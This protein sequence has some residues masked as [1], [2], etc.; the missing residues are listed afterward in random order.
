MLLPRNPSTKRHRFCH[1]TTWFF[2]VRRWWRCA[3]LWRLA[4]PAGKHQR[5]FQRPQGTPL[6]TS[7]PKTGSTTQPKQHGR[8]EA[9]HLSCRTSTM[10]TSWRRHSLFC[11][12]Q[13]YTQIGPFTP[14]SLFVWGFSATCCSRHK[15]PL[16]LPAGTVL[17]RKCPHVGHRTSL[18]KPTSYAECVFSV[19]MRAITTTSQA[20][21]SMWVASVPRWAKTSA[22][23]A[24]YAMRVASV[25]MWATT[26]A[27]QA[28]YAMCV[29]SVHMCAISTAS[30]AGY[31]MCVTSVP[32]WAI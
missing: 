13:D 19:T 1:G 14:T 7:S 22:S 15:D 4:C 25:S 20:E 32:M 8:H 3:Q 23:Q 26:T 12:Q 2:A 28:E 21:Y 9:A 27:S 10:T 31:A 5:H 16:R 29:A 11:S 18:A 30:Q 24:E 6:S 17:F